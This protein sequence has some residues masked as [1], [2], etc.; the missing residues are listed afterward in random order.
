MNVESISINVY[1]L[2]D[3]DATF[4]FVTLLVAINFNILHENIFSFYSVVDSIVSKRVYKS[5]PISL[6][7]RFTFVYLIELD[8][9]DFVL[10]WGW[11]GYMLVLI[12]FNL[13]RSYSCFNILMNSS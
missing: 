2:L 6:S 5:C 12:L 10:Y 4:S 1:A 13:E 8:M 9:F 7:S 3:L 11:I